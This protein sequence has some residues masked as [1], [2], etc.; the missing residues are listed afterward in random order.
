[1]SHKLF[2]LDPGA[3]VTVHYTIMSPEEFE[4]KF[5]ITFEGLLKGRQVKVEDFQNTALRNVFQILGKELENYVAK[6]EWQES[7]S[8]EQEW[9]ESYTEKQKSLPKKPVKKQTLKRFDVGLVNGNLNKLVVTTNRG[10]HTI[11][12]PA[13]QQ[14]NQSAGA[15]IHQAYD[16]LVQSAVMPQGQI[17]K[18]EKSDQVVVKNAIHDLQLSEAKPSKDSKAL[19]ALLQTLSDYYRNKKDL[20]K[21]IVEEAE[22]SHEREKRAM[23]KESIKKEILKEEIVEEQIEDIL[24]KVINLSAQ[25]GWEE[26]DERHESLEVRTKHY[27]QFLKNLFHL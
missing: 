7:Y 25:L 8:E 2:H 21:E 15:I 10:T 23:K 1:M 9:K 11:T 5:D 27:R 14:L 12:G 16:G 18:A 4:R 24:Q 13:L 22:R 17:P 19:L 20:L 3:G 26:V 6:Q